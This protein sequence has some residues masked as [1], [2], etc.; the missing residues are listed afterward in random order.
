[1]NKKLKDK[2]KENWQIYSDR[3]LTASILGRGVVLGILVLSLR[4]YEIN[5]AYFA[6]YFLLDTF[7]YVLAAVS[8][9]TLAKLQELGKIK[10]GRPDWVNYPAKVCWLGKFGILF[11]LLTVLVFHV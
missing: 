4:W 2:N 3:S 9:N 1:M 7:Q 5:I 6:A 8:Y 10:I 11:V